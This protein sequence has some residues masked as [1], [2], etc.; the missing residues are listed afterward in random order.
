MALR[1]EVVHL[2]GF[3]LLHDVNQAARVGHIAVMQHKPAVSYM[4][5]LVKMVDSIGIQ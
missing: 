4:R 1:R 2:I 3:D 5:I